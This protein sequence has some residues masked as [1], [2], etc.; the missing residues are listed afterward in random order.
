MKPSTVFFKCQWKAFKTH[1]SKS[2]DYYVVSIKWLPGNPRETEG[3]NLPWKLTGKCS[4]WAPLQ[5][6]LKVPRKVASWN[7]SNWCSQSYDNRRVSKVIPANSGGD[8]ITTGFDVLRKRN[9]EE[10]EEGKPNKLA[11]Y[12]RI[13]MW[14][15][16][17]FGW[18]GVANRKKSAVQAKEIGWG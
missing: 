15:Y 10:Q 14:E 9:E 16:M 12:V 13:S 1:G 17:Q 18:I 5:I 2:L 3:D 8:A 11:M 6:G 7:L 4:L